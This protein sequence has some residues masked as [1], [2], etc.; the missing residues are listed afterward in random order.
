MRE[1]ATWQASYDYWRMADIV[2][3]SVDGRRSMRTQ[4]ET[5][6]RPKES[7]IDGCSLRKVDEWMYILADKTALR[8]KVE[9]TQR[10]MCELTLHHVRVL[11]G[12]IYIADYSSCS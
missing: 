5:S 11:N 2:D 3:S 8:A 4:I 12:V 1:E 9:A 7:R 10:T 6:V